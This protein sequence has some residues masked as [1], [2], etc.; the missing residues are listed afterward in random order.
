MMRFVEKTAIITMAFLALSCASKPDQKPAV[1]LPASNEVPGWTKTGETRAFAADKL[2]E[3]ING[4][5]ERYVQAGVERTLTADYRFQEKVEAVA[6]IYIMKTPDGA[7]KIFAS[8]SA[9][10]SQAIKLGEDAR[11]FPTSL[12]FRKGRFLVR[13]TAFQEAPE[14]SKALVE[15]GQAVERGLGD[16]G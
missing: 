2:W 16:G 4:D 11:L 9:A 14:V 5:A 15:L 6:D 8:E 13:L 3:Y 12:V 1:L 10:G 7:R